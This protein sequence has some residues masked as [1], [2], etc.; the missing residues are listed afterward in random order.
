MPWRPHLNSR[1][2]SDYDLLVVLPDAVPHSALVRVPADIVP[3]TRSE[4]EEG[5]DEVDTL[6]RAA[7]RHGHKLYVR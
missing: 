7:T 4:F 1:P 5:K 3:C 6:A 2:N